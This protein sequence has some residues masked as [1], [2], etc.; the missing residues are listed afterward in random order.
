MDS[1]CKKFKK[2]ISSVVLSCSMVCSCGFANAGLVGEYSNQEVWG[3][4]FE[5]LRDVECKYKGIISKIRKSNDGVSILKR[6][7]YIMNPDFTGRKLCE[8]FC[9][10]GKDTK[11]L[12]MQSFVNKEIKFDELIERCS[13]QLDKGEK[14]CNFF[15]AC[16]LV[17]YLEAFNIKCALTGCSKFDFNDNLKCISCDDDFKFG[18]IVPVVDDNGGFV[19]HDIWLPVIKVMKVDDNSAGLNID[20]EV[21]DMGDF[22]NDSYMLEYVFVGEKDAKFLGLKGR[23]G[24]NMELVTPVSWME[25]SKLDDIYY[26]DSDYKS[27]S[28]LLEPIDDKYFTQLLSSNT[29]LDKISGSFFSFTGLGKK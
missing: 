6:L 18:V 10:G 12:I 25:V 3:N 21:A 24:R 15:L 8:N 17:R 4:L 5:S 7:S 22:Y 23:N 9:V 1:I 26:G 27:P 19:S 11:K 2:V 29:L 16:W 20:I 28:K 13:E 14:L